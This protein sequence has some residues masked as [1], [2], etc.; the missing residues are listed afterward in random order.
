[1][2]AFSEFP[3]PQIA[4]QTQRPAELHRFLCSIFVSPPAHLRYGTRW[5]KEGEVQPNLANTNQNTVLTFP[6]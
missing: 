4:L 1:M 2:N 5:A 3:D 6:G